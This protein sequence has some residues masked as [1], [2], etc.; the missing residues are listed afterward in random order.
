MGAVCQ[1]NDVALP[2]SDEKKYEAT[3]GVSSNKY[4][5]DPI[6]FLVPTTTI[7]FESFIFENITFTIIVHQTS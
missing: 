3:I 7:S 5:S 2:E 1:P 6:Y 4:D